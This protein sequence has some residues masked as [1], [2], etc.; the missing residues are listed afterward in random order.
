M[1]LLLHASWYAMDFTYLHLIL[2][3]LWAINK[4]FPESIQPSYYE[5]ETSI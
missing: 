2:V 1:N 5:M 3:T 4:V